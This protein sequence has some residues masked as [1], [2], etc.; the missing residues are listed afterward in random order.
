MRRAASSVSS[1]RSDFEIADCNS[2]SASGAAKAVFVGDR[3]EVL[4]VMQVQRQPQD[5]DITGLR[6]VGARFRP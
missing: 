1:T 4:Q 6:L 5:G 3:E 2:P